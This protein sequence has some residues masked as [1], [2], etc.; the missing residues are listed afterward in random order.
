M[1]FWLWLTKRLGAS[2]LFGKADAELP[3]GKTRG[4][5]RWKG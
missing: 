4:K 3:F 1:S 5:L 2:D